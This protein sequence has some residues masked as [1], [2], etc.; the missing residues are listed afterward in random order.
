MGRGVRTHSNNQLYKRLYYLYC[1]L[2]PISLVIA[3]YYIFLLLHSYGNFGMRPRVLLH[4]KEH[5]L[6]SLIVMQL[7]IF[8]GSALFLSDLPYSPSLSLL[9]YNYQF[10]QK[11]SNQKI[12]Y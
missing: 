8:F 10:V 7:S 5:Y 3:L 1:R 2:G 12:P 9:A 4:T 11:I 6:V